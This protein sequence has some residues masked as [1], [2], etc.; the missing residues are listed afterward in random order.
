VK[1]GEKGLSISP[2]Y[3]CLF[4]VAVAF[5]WLVESAIILSSFT[6]HNVYISRGEWIFQS[7]VWGLPVVFFLL[8]FWLAAQKLVGLRQR[9]FFAML[10]TVIVAS[11]YDAL[12][13]VTQHLYSA[14]YTANHPITG[15]SFWA[16]YGSE[17]AAMITAVVFFAGS[18]LL[19]RKRG[20]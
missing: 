18:L 1:K 3:Q 13:I 5:A 15:G 7:T 11:L 10:L 2:F 6:G 16:A 19:L 9:I 4:V 14:Y 8:S 17:W 20:V 12:D